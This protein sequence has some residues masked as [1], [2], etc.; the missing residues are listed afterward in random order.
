MPQLYCPVCKLEK[1]FKLPWSA[2]YYAA[3]GTVH[4]A[5]AGPENEKLR[6]LMKSRKIGWNDYSDSHCGELFDYGVEGTT[7]DC[8]GVIYV[9]LGRWSGGR[10]E[11]IVG[12]DTSG[13]DDGAAP[14]DKEPEPGK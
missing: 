7:K 5:I 6:A 4:K 12:E 10:V 14:P 1:D 8:P 11:K 3:K 13:L 9:R 2:L